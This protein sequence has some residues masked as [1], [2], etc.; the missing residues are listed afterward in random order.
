MRAVVIEKAQ[1]L[2]ISEIPD[3]TPG[4]DEVLIRVA[5][6]GICGSDLHYYFEGRNGEFRL[7][8]PLIPG[9]EVSG[10]I[11]HDP[12]GELEP[13][14]PV[15][16]HPA[17]A[18][19]PSQRLASRPNLWPKTAY[20]GSAGTYPHTQGAMAQFLVMPRAN[21]VPLPAGLA[22]TTAAL[23]EPLA[24][25]LH[26]L[27]LAGDVEGKSVL[28]TGAGAIGQL[29]A[30]AVKSDGAGH[31]AISDID[32]IALDR[33]RTLGVDE[34]LLVNTD[35]IP[36]EKY[37]IAFECSGSGAGLASTLRGVRRAGQVIQVGVLPSR[38][39]NVDLSPLVSKEI[40]ITGSFRFNDEIH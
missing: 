20:L 15:T 16:V 29:T 30:L 24:V 6:V 36:A 38:V 35:G 5:Y 7:R 32:K 17:R 28:I 18:G 37:D 25:C 19:E 8:E 11:A 31:V 23:A 14:T 2:S 3:P 22:M 10:E 13:G 1:H 12:S 33:A 34:V 4:A 39:R 27:N 21:I 26:A 40:Q 9:H